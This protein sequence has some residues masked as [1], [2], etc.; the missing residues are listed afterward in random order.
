MRI[1]MISEHAS[2]LATI[3]G[4]DSGGQNIYVAQVAR[5]L[6]DQGHQV[7]VFT[8]RDDPELAS[9]VE[10]VAGLR[11]VHVT[12]GPQAFVP[13]EK[14]LEHMPEFARFCDAW[15]RTA[16]PY[17]VVHANFFMSG[18][19][20]LQLQE[21]FDLP[22]VTTFHALGLVR[23]E[24]QKETDAFPAER[25][26]IERALAARSDRL[27]AECPQDVADLR[28]LYRADPA[29]MAMVPCGFDA[30]E[31][32]PQ[33]RAEA[34]ARLGL[35][36][37][38]FMVLQLGRMVPRKGVETV[39]RAMACAPCDGMRLRVVGGDCDLPDPEHTPEIGRLQAI[40]RECGVAERVVFEGRKTRAALCDWYA[41]ADVF[42]TTPWYEPFG[43]TPL[44]AM[45]CAR[46]VVGSAVGG[47][48]YSVLDGVTG[49]LVPPKDP[50][51][52]ATALASLRA[53][54]DR[55]AAMGDAG[56]A[57]ARLAFTWHGVARQLSTV[58]AEAVA[59]RASQHQPAADASILHVTGFD[60]PRERPAATTT[61]RPAVFIDKDGTLVHDVPYNV[62]PSL[63]RFTPHAIEAL[64]LWRDAGYRLVVV[65]NQSG[66]GRG[67]FDRAALGRLHDALAARLAR[68]GVPIDG[69][70]ACPHV[71]A[72]GCDCRKPRDGL[73]REAARA[74]DIDL[75]Q[76][77]MVG[78]ILND[79]EAGHRA[80][81]GSVLLDVGHETEWHLTELRRPDHVCA[82]L[83]EAAQATWRPAPA[84]LHHS[85]PRSRVEA[86][87]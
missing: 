4:V 24:H 48:Q 64:R 76:S 6:V 46:P 55:A 72:D 41:A 67:L 51:A 79:V 70:F 10:V 26:D 19:V 39:V 57:R 31:F 1:A 84:P 78:D 13:K 42:V 33:S 85:A 27:V 14:L 74:L 65:T 16:P 15:M 2:P 11:V 5:H 35:P 75:E 9:V 12:A 23:R 25:I 80:G 44:E 63:V 49:V 83:L 17:D 69:F 28:R 22:L 59:S 38:E 73:L 54:P 77:W 81:C 21:M 47:V 66:L 50:V 8:R 29:R 56:L 20:G 18:W 52:L 7:D 61:R 82:D 58:F 45:A 37:D 86:A 36:A 3:G 30:S 71:D 32:T 53:D 40:A 62:D 87:A 43:I 60:A 68:A 34:R